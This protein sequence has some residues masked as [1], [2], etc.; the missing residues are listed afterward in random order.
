[1]IRSQFL[2]ITEHNRAM[3]DTLSKEHLMYHIRIQKIENNITHKC[4][5]CNAFVVLTFFVQGN[6][7][8]LWIFACKCIPYNDRYRHLP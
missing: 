5:I 2:C 6:K 7:N 1:M 4:V 8:K 3:V